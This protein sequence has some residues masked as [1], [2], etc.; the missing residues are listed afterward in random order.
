MPH[1]IRVEPVFEGGIV[2]TLLVQCGCGAS[3][4]VTCCYAEDTNEQG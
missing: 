2:T 4:E 1:Q 3:T